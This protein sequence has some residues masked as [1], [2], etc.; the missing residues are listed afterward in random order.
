MEEKLLEWFLGVMENDGVDL[1]ET[2]GAMKLAIKILKRTEY[3]WEKKA[4]VGDLIGKE[5]TEDAE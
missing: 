5:V 3:S 2:K 4:V 1:R